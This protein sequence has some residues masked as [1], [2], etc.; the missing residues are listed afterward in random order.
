MVRSIDQQ[1]TIKKALSAITSHETQSS[2]GDF[3]QGN[4]AQLFL[5]SLQ[6]DDIWQVN[7]QKQFRDLE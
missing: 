6:K 7:H 4:S 1:T 5:E 3:G 2:I